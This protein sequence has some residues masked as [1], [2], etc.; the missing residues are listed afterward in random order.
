MEKEL[1]FEQDEAWFETEKE[2]NDF[3][4]LKKSVSNKTY[5]KFMIEHI[6]NDDK[7]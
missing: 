1:K 6:F 5:G 7:L 4:N 2:A 3:I